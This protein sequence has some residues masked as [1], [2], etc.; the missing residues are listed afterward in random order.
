VGASR[1]DWQ[2]TAQAASAPI[3]AQAPPIVVEVPATLPEEAPANSSADAGAASPAARAP[4][5]AGRSDEELLGPL[6]AAPLKSV[7]LK[8]GGLTL[9]FKLVFEN[10]AEAAFKPNQR[11][12]TGGQE[13]R[14]EIAA[15]RI[16]RLLG[17]VRV[18]PAI[19]RSFPVLAIRHAWGGSDEK[20]IQLQTD[21]ISH[22]GL[23]AGEVSWWIPVIK[24]ARIEGEQIDEP[25]GEAIWRRY[26]TI[27]SDIPPGVRD[28]VVQISNMIVFDLIINNSDRWAG[29]NTKMSEDGTVL[30]YMDNT[31]AFGRD[32]RGA[33]RL[34]GQLRKV[35][36]F[37]RS[38]V[39]KLRSLS[40]ET[41]RRVLAEAPDPF[42]ELLHPDEIDALFARREQLLAY[43]DALATKKGEAAVLY[44]P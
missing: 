10:G 6:R 40:E 13:P 14:Y 24:A 23:V 38:L 2:G 33:P 1:D 12:R 17:L 21:L 16:D 37:S 27:G 9:S 8:G 7:K 34:W 36:R 26:L 41:L 3:P 22:G 42:K 18:P 19:G 25:S 39:A 43:I 31:L 32:K 4:L 28:M 44:F 20:R 11:G 30:Y 35:Q 15:Y 29:A 5:F